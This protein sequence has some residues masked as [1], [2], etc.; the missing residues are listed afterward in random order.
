MAQLVNC[1]LSKHRD[2]SSFPCTCVKVR[3]RDMCL[4]P[5]SWDKETGGSLGLRTSWSSQINSL[6]LKKKLYPFFIEKKSLLSHTAHPHQFPF[7]PLL[8][9]SPSSRSISSFKRQQLNMTKQDTIAEG[10]SWVRQL[11]GGK[12]SHEQAKERPRASC[13]DLCEPR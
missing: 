4:C 8:P 9:A 3:H 5:Q 6:F 1:L 11:T 10:K 7:L 13:L 12:E 2:L